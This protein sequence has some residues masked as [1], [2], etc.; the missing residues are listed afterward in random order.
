VVYEQESFNRAGQE[1]LMAQSAVSKHIQDLEA[2]LGTVLFERSSRGVRPTKAGELLYE[3]ALKMLRLLAEA[4]REIIHI[5]QL[6]DRQLNVGTTPGVSVYLLP[7]WFQ[8]FQLAYPNIRVSLQTILTQEVVKGI[9]VG[10]YDLG[11]LEG[12]LQEL[13]QDMLGK[14]RLSEIEYFVSVDASHPWSN[15]ETISV[16]ELADQPFINRQP[17]SRTRRWLE[18]KLAEYDIHLRNIA[19]LD[20]PG[21]IKYALLSKMGVSILPKYA[22][23]REIERN[24]LHLLQIDALRLTRPLLMVWNKNQP[25]NPIQRAFVTLLAEDMPQ[26][27]I[28]L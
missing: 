8:K 12:E 15:R 28:L 24:E 3:Y 13:D 9:L 10:R 5:S 14:M 22:V 18:Q 27:L 25:F 1:L 11:F 7:P 6:Q 19:E 2:S 26:L 17:S 4:E 23:E 21:T 16:S 20:S